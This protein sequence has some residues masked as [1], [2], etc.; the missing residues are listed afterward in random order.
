MQKLFKRLS[1]I[2]IFVALFVTVP[3]VFTKMFSY[4]FPDSPDKLIFMLSGILFLG[5][6]LFREKLQNILNVKH[7]FYLYLFVIYSFALLALI[8]IIS[9]YL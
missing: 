8:F 6:Y 5:L 7:F 3:A 2:L 1:D 9:F 4:V